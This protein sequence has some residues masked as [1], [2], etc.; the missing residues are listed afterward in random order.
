MMRLTEDSVLLS[1]PQSPYSREVQLAEK[2]TSC[3]RNTNSTNSDALANALAVTLNSPVL[4][5]NALSSI[6]DSA[7]WSERVFATPPPSSEKRAGED[8]QLR[9]V[10]RPKLMREPSLQHVPRTAPTSAPITLSGSAVTFSSSIFSTIAKDPAGFRRREDAFLDF[11]QRAPSSSLRSYN[12]ATSAAAALLKKRAAA[13][14]AASSR[15]S[16]RRSDDGGYSSTGSGTRSMTSRAAPT[17]SA[18]RPQRVLPQRVREVANGSSYKARSASPA[19]ASPRATPSPKKR[20]VAPPSSSPAVPSRVHDTDYAELPDYCP[21]T[22]SLPASGR[23]LKAEWKGAPMDLSDDP[24]VDKLHPAEVYLASCLR[25]SCET[26]LDSKR[27]LFAEKVHRLK[28]GLP[29]RRTD[30]QKACRIDVN[31]ASRLFSAYEKVGW[32]DDELFKKFL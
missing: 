30:S 19:P 4:S 25:L 20:V 29:F 6:R 26:Y 11:Y 17:S 28:F 8:A 27:R 7:E 12:N 3:P 2:P 15:A 23:P 10:K 21:S 13:S 31:K 32:L 9:D 18:A 24:A 5:Q 1:P 14:A 22:D 16:G